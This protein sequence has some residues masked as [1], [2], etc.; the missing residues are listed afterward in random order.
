LGNKQ[1]LNNIIKNC[2]YHRRQPLLRSR[3]AQHHT[4]C[5]LGGVLDLLHVLG[6]LLNNALAQ[7]RNIFKISFSAVVDVF[8]WHTLH[9]L[10]IVDV[11][12]F[13]D[14]SRDSS[15]GPLNRV[16]LP[17]GKFLRK[18]FTHFYAGKLSLNQATDTFLRGYKIWKYKI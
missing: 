18:H 9:S 7:A 16:G 12:F 15:S 8:W 2:T 13:Y 1:N 17:Q 3:A 6:P 14:L 5:L 10:G 4:G 11:K